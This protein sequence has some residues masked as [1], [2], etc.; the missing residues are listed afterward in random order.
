MRKFGTI[1]F[2]L[3][4]TFLLIISIASQAQ[5]TA[6]ENSVRIITFSSD[7][8]SCRPGKTNKFNFRIGYEK[9]WLFKQGTIRLEIQ[10]MPGKTTSFSY[11]FVLKKEDI[12]N[13]F[14]TFKAKLKIGDC[15]QVKAV[16]SLDLKNGTANVVRAMIIPVAGKA[17]LYDDFD[18]NGN[19]QPDGSQ[20]TKTKALPAN[21]YYITEQAKTSFKKWKNHKQTLRLENPSGNIGSVSLFL[22]NPHDININDGFIIEADLMLDKTSNSDNFNGSI[23]LGGTLDINGKEEWWGFSL[24]LSKGYWGEGI[25]TGYVDPETKEWTSGK[26]INTNA[27]IWHKLKIIGTNKRN[28]KLIVKCYVDGKLLDKIIYKN[29]RGF[30]DGGFVYGPRRE[31]GSW[32]EKEKG[33]GIVYFDNIKSGYNINS[34]INNTP[35][36][37]PLYDDFDGNGNYYDGSNH[38]ISGGLA[39]TIWKGSATN[40]DIVDFTDIDSSQPQHGFVLKLDKSKYLYP[41]MTFKYGWDR[42][43]SVSYDIYLDSSSTTGT[44][45]PGRIGSFIQEIHPAQPEAPPGK[46]IYTQWGVNIES[47]TPYMVTNITNK[48]SLHRGHENDDETRIWKRIADLEFDR[49]YNIRLDAVQIS[50]Y[51]YKQVYYL[52]GVEKFSVVLPDNAFMLNPNN[53]LDPRKS[54]SAISGSF[55]LNMETDQAKALLYIDNFRLP[56][57]CDEVASLQAPYARNSSTPEITSINTSGFTEGGNSGFFIAPVTFTFKDRGKDLKG[58]WL[59]LSHDE[60]TTSN[61]VF[62]YALQ[63]PA[64]ESES[65]SFTI[66]PIHQTYTGIITAQ[67]EDSNFNRSDPLTFEFK[68]NVG[69]DRAKSFTLTPSNSLYDNFDGQGGYFQANNSNLSEPGFISPWLWIVSAHNRNDVSVV[70]AS[71]EINDSKS[72]GFCVKAFHRKQFQGFMNLYLSSPY[73]QVLFNGYRF[74]RE[75]NLLTWQNIGSVK[76][77]ICLSS[78]STSKEYA[79]GIEVGFGYDHS[80]DYAP[81]CRFRRLVLRKDPE[82]GNFYAAFH[83]E[84]R[85]HPFGGSPSFFKNLKRI[86]PD[87]WYTLKLDTRV[88]NNEIVFRCYLNNEEIYRRVAEDSAV[89]LSK[90]YLGS[91]SI[92]STPHRALILHKPLPDGVAIAYFDNVY[93]TYENGK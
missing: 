61:K 82:D 3:L 7:T 48:N 5:I 34:A 13:G 57:Y 76:A 11:N 72:E 83:Y 71:S 93:A 1:T 46:S 40:D 88:E 22:N 36:A 21:L 58:G 59:I 65:G 53:R 91:F 77:N 38:T 10:E 80:P 67:L 62:K 81:R 30:Q 87:K 37:A 43:Q 9:M 42:F 24:F 63:H 35:N 52:D 68:R 32:K 47:P 60:K 79:A 49:W 74:P 8:S 18:G 20:L 23:G 14:F 86:N 84:N 4:F 75:E 92:W 6:S 89:A 25:G 39:S 33:N 78:K 51:E 50:P 56:F 85:H 27:H 70:K 64:T 69:Y 90:T 41:D 66:Y 73:F 31:L 12:E 28:K 26:F 44:N 55:K 15:E 54:A 45:K 19:E 16:C 2:L 29:F 17:P